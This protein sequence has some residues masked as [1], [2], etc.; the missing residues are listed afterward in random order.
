MFLFSGY[1]PKIYSNVPN[2]I[3]DHKN[4]LKQ[5]KGKKITDIWIAWD[6]DNNEWFNDC[7]VVISFEDC[8]LE[9]CA[10]KSDEYKISF[11]EIPIF[12]PIDWYGTNFNLEW[13]KNKLPFQAS[14]TNKRVKHMEIIE[15]YN[16]EAGVSLS[17]H[18]V[19]FQLEDSYFAVCNGLD[20]NMLITE[21]LDSRNYRCTII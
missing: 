11:N 3:Q 1:S 5:L 18:G 14:L 17:L 4:C 21:K 9:L 16:G 13:V 15:V 19:G 10:Y 12:Q 2:I 20:E 7:P 8:Q 6:K